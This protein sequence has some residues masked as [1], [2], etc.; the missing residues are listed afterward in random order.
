MD[1]EVDLVFAHLPKVIKLEETGMFLFKF[2]G[3][4]HLLLKHNKITSL[5]LS[6]VSLSLSL[7]P[8]KVKIS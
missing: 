8:S 1:I 7:P 3:I 2:I 5:S 6:A 4:T